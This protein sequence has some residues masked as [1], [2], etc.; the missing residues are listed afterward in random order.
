MDCADNRLFTLVTAST[1]LCIICVLNADEAVD[2]PGDSLR[3]V[4]LIHS[5]MDNLWMIDPLRAHRAGTIFAQVLRRLDIQFLPDVGNLLAH[6]IVEFH[7]FFDFF[8]GVDS[9]GVVFAPKFAG[10][11]REAQVQFAA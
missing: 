9:S 7:G 10:D 6:N 11:F 5:R 3:S 2:R 4:R 1:G 8:N